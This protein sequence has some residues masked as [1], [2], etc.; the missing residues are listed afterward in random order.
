MLLCLFG[1]D[2][3][4]LSGRHRTQRYAVHRT[5]HVG[6]RMLRSRRR[7]SLKN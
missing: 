7:M 3:A 1:Q 2:W 5:D 4:E 6:I